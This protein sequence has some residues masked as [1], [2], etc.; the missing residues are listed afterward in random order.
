[1][2]FEM[3]DFNKD[4]IE[5]SYSI[6]VL[7]DFWAEWC[8]P[9]KALSPILERLA[10]R[11]ND[12]WVLVKV[13]T[14]KNPDISQ[15]Y[16]IRGIPNIKLFSN[17][18]IINEFTGALPENMVLDWL[19]KAIP[20]KNQKLIDQAAELLTQD[21]IKEAKEILE[22]VFKSEPQNEQVK[23]LI[24]KALVFED[25]A[26]SIELLSSIDELS[27]FHETVDSI[28]TF[29]RMF[30]YLDDKN[31]LP[32][33]QVKDLYLNAI[34]EVK[35]K[36]FASALEKF[37]EVIRSNR[38]YDNDGARKACIAIFKFLGEE[39]EITLKYR[40]DFSSALYV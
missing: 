32:D 9:C 23:V 21:K 10:E 12:Q 39:N 24:A 34:T 7:V 36:K 1:M 22:K 37:I 19:K 26:G 17:G 20:G 28:K 31:S 6:P 40:R 15:E 5:Q 11:F 2:N 33:N 4:V 16:G 38:Y 35:E 13:D 14:D 18:N 30:N 27:E 25:H 8:G 3:T 29:A